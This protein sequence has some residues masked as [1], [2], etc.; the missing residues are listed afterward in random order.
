MFR[1]SSVQTR[2]IVGDSSADIS[3]AHTD[4]VKSNNF[5][6]NFTFVNSKAINTTAFKIYFQECYSI[7]ITEI[8]IKMFGH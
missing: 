1:V 7:A 2:A 4:N 3:F 5:N 8:S 6:D